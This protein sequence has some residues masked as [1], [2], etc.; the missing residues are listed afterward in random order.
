MSIGRSA[1]S[2]KVALTLIGTLAGTWRA[3]DFRPDPAAGAEFGLDHAILSA[4]IPLTAVPAR[5]GKE[6]RQKLLRE[7]LPGA[8]Q[9]RDLAVAG[10][11]LDFKQLLGSA[12]NQ[13]CQK[14]G[15]RVSLACVV[16]R[17]SLSGGG[18]SM[19]RL[20]KL[21]ALSMER[22]AVVLDL[23]SATVPPQ[24]AHAALKG[25]IGRYTANLLAGRGAEHR[26][27]C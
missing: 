20:F 2:P 18:D 9:I 3:F 16:Q 26:L 24:R 13:K 6:R 12:G 1:A 4:S 27:R 19:D 21:V 15:G 11:P 14:Y 8:R 23:A 25:D 22:L 5:A 7:L 17:F 10:E